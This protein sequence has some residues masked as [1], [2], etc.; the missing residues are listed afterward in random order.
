MHMGC[1]G[2]LSGFPSPFSFPAT[3]LTFQISE[4]FGS[5]LKKNICNI[6]I[7]M[8][9]NHKGFFATDE[10]L[11]CSPLALEEGVFEFGLGVWVGGF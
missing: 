2:F 4:V 6:N 5:F 7:L 3:F 10:R 8:Q 9:G 1:N 11:R